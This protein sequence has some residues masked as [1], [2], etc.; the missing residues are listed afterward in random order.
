M[1]DEILKQIGLS[2]LQI[3]AYLYLLDKGPTPPPDIAK[4]LK[5]TRS[6]AYKV[7]DQLVEFTIVSRLDTNRKLHYKAEDPIALASIAANERNRVIALEKNIKEALTQL[8]QTYQKS[9]G[10]TEVQTYRGA[11]AVKSLY[12]HQAALKQTI[13][14]VK[15][16]AD[17]PSM[18]FEVM[19]SIRRLPAKFGTQRFGIVPDA[20]E[21]AT[22]PDINKRSNLTPTWIAAEFYTAPVEW[23]VADDELMIITF[24]ETPSGIRIKNKVVADAFLQLWTTIDQSL[25]TSPGYKKMP[26]KAKRKI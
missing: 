18:G 20:P 11:E 24:D 6:N 2:D 21:S 10:D 25:R 19:D 22:N 4:N 14:F 7:L 3:S 23:T 26:L 16:R 8:R 9:S 1:K 13:H 12:K 15:S 5:I 17:I